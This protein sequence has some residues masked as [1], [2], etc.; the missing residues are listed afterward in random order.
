LKDRITQKID[1]SQMVRL[2][3]SVSPMAQSSVDQGRVSETMRINGAELIFGPSPAQKAAL[4]ALIAQQHDRSSPNYHRWLSPEEYA[5]RFSLSPAD[6]QKVTAWLAAQGLEIE[7]VSRTR[8]RVSFSGSA[9]GVA[10]AFKTEFHQ[11]FVDNEQHYANATEVAIPSALSESVIAVRHFDD[12]RW[13]AQNIHARTINSPSPRFTVGN[14]TFLAPADVATI[15]NINPLYSA[16]YDGTGQRIAVVGRTQIF[17]RDINDFRS[18]GG[19][20]VNPPQVV[21]VPN[22]GTAVVKNSDLIEADLDIEWAGGIAKNATIIYVFSGNL[23]DVDTALQYA[24]EQKIAPVISI[25][26]G[27]CETSTGTAQRDAVETLAAEANSFGQTIVSAIG[28]LG[29]ADCD[30]GT[31][32]V[33]THGLAVDL[34]GAV[35]EV[36]A[37]GGTTFSGDDNVNPLYWNTFNDGTTN[38]SAKMY[39][40][41]VVWNDTASRGELASGG[42]GVSKLTAKPAFQNA[43]T[44]NDGKRD[45]PDIALSASPDHDG[46]VVCSNNGDCATGFDVVGGTSVGAPVFAGMLALI[47][48]A[49]ENSAGQGNV[50][51]TL[52]SLAGVPA[53]YNL[54]FHDITTGDNKVPCQ[55]GTPD[56]PASAPFLIGFSAGTKYDLATG[57]GSVNLANLANA[58]PGFNASPAV[59][60]FGLTATPNPITISAPGQSGSSTVTVA[61]GTGFTGTVNLACKV[62]NTVAEVGC[63]LNMAS[64]NLSAGTNTVDVTLSVSTSAAHAISGGMTATNRWLAAGSVTLVGCVFLI[65]MPGRHRRWPT[66]SALTVLL[67]LA[68]SPACGGGSSGGGTK[69][70]TTDPG[71]VAGSYVV[72]VT[73]SNSG[74][75]ISHSV[76]VAV[77]VQ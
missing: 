40:P 27:F 19:L 45:V 31:A 7:E 73:G 48:Q 24:V 12:F 9:A 5:D 58:W 68:L 23:K 77:T 44:P 29:A 25:S 56:C 37:V 39:I 63:T 69:G 14:E 43:L 49:T 10:A 72:A 54:A 60:A 71:T 67:L 30:S 3:G 55:S 8:N 59:D 62:L 13:R 15:Y 70:G 46:Y 20:S 6:I 50:N 35:P 16:G 64:V 18:G 66:L 53:T 2:R 1:S 57:L 75:S 11:Y 21:L 17:A 42:G 33:A 51:F 28:D 26:Y 41:E 47:N 38:G 34:P 61:S 76:N 36:T 22:S 52:Y 4:Q 65:A 74:G 32:S